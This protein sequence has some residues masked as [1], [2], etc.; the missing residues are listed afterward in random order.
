MSAFGV[1]RSDKDN[2]YSLT[3]GMVGQTTL[4][5]G[6]FGITG[7][8]I[9]GQ[10]QPWTVPPAEA[11]T[12]T[13]TAL[14]EPMPVQLDGKDVVAIAYVQSV[15]GSGTQKAKG[16]VLF[17][18]IDPADGKKVAEVAADL[19]PLL[20]PGATGDNVVDQAYDAATGQIVIGV[21]PDTATAKSGGIFTVFADPK[22]QKSSLI[23]S[24]EPAG[25]LNG[26]VAGVNG[27]DAAGRGT[28]TIL[29]ADAATGK[30]TKQFPTKQASLWSAGHGSKRAYVS[31]STSGGD[32]FSNVVYSIDIATGAVVPIPA[33]VVDHLM[34]F[35]CLGDEANAVVCVE[36]AGNSSEIIGIDDTTGKKTWGYTDKAANR[37][38]PDVT[39]AF[40]GVVYGQTDG[41]A[42]DARCSHR[43]RRSDQRADTI[44]QHEPVGRWQ[45][46]GEQHA[47]RGCDSE[48][49]PGLA[50]DRPG[51]CERFGHVPV[52]RQARVADRGDEVRRRLLA[53]TGRLQ[54]P[55]RADRAQADR[56][57]GPHGEGLPGVGSPFALRR[58]RCRCGG[59][60]GRSATAWGRVGPGS[61]SRT[62]SEPYGCSAGDESRKKQSW[63]IFMPGQSL[64]GSVATLDSSSVTC[65]ENPGS[66][67]PAV[68]C[69]SSPSRP[70]ED[71]PSSRA[72][73]SSG[74]VTSSYVDPRTNS[75]G[76][77][78]NG[79][80]PSGSTSRV[81]SGCS[82]A[83]SMCGYLWFS[84][85]RK[86]RSSRTSTLDGCTIAASN[87]SSWTRFASSS[88]RM[89]RSESSTV[90]R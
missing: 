4:I 6:K 36:G 20:G 41:T 74:S 58:T 70:S 57:I 18:W 76:C 52:Q 15:T 69:V 66:M 59:S 84:K 82:S 60:S 32:K 81:R 77:R 12:T 24:F 67:N 11:E 72:A 50:G 8:N 45:P 65:P 17:Q 43:E 34:K 2:Q 62:W 73:T 30:I 27:G 1:P 40:H 88:A 90:A 64:I 55:E 37:I 22:T 63:P 48:R 31:G 56:L 42:G 46:V 19:T 26:V 44:G 83:G 54:L 49:G 89:S 80:S 13:I 5:A 29:I 16:Q 86:N 25:V 10:G 38:V 61:G 28:T 7:R 78:M 21:H 85:T 87:G 79:S 75:P 3:S 68:E 51:Q 39:A 35:R 71:L 14:T 9:A 23:P 47:D 33:Q 53:G